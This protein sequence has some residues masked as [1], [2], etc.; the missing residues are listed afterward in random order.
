MPDQ[1]LVE[2]LKNALA[3]GPEGLVCAYLFGS[4]ALGS[5]TPRTLAGLH[6]DLAD[7]LTGMSSS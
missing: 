3:R 5:A 4:H 1:H 6:L 2:I 7:D